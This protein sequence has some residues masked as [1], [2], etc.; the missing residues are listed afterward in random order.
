MSQTLNVNGFSGQHGLNVWFR[1]IETL[2]VFSVCQKRLHSQISEPEDQSLGGRL[3]GLRQ[4]QGFIH[5]RNTSL[6]AAA[7]HQVLCQCQFQAE[8]GLIGIQSLLQGIFHQQIDLINHGLGVSLV[9]DHL[10]CFLQGPGPFHPI[11]YSCRRLQQNRFKG[12][13]EG[14]NICGLNRFSRFG[15]HHHQSQASPGNLFGLWCS[16]IHRCVQNFGERGRI[17]VALVRFPVQFRL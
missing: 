12:R 6:I 7:C 11:I 9:A 16:R 2:L 5:D 13:S 8:V 4:F 3:L 1:L 14:R 15:F 10:A 17:G